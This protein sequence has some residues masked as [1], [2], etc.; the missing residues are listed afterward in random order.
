MGPHKSF[1]MKR[2]QLGKTKR[3]E[4]SKK[5]GEKDVDNFIAA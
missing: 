5:K 2:P 1:G 3:D 4:W